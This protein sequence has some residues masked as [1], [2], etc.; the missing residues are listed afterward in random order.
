MTLFFLLRS[1]IENSI[2]WLSL[3]N[4]SCSLGTVCFRENI[5]LLFLFCSSHS[6][7]CSSYKALHCASATCHNRPQQRQKTS[8]DPCTKVLTLKTKLP[9]VSQSHCRLGCS[10]RGMWGTREQYESISASWFFFLPNWDHNEKWIKW[11]NSFLQD[12][13]LSF[14]SP[15][16]SPP[17]SREFDTDI[18][19]SRMGLRPVPCERPLLGRMQQS[20]LKLEKRRR[21]CW[22]KSVAVTCL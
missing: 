1:C 19:K 13:D 4:T 9:L 2:A 14:L 18:L 7:F 16:L 10:D 21:A 6:C 8:N 5:I 15:A 3:Q 11:W 12:Y 20:H 22:G 17:V